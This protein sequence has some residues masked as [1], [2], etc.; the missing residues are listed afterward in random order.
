[1]NKWILLFLTLV[2]LTSQNCKSL[3]PGTNERPQ[4]LT[5]EILSGQDV[6]MSDVNIRESVSFQDVMDD[7]E[8]IVIRGA[9]KFQNCTFED[10]FDLIPPMSG[11]LTFDKEVVFEGCIFKSGFKINDAIFNGRFQMNDCLVEGSLDIQ[12]NTFRHR[13][14]I[15][16]SKVGQDLIL[17]YSRMA[18]DLSIFETEAGRH[19]SL[20]GISVAGLCQLSSSSMG[21]S[22]VISNAHFHETFMANYVNIGKKLL[23]GNSRFNGRADFKDLQCKD[24]IKLSNSEFIGKMSISLKNGSPEVNLEDCFFLQGAPAFH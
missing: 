6:I 10:S 19:F 5:Q 4:N 12:R 17:Q 23:A 7:H 2:G 13:C 21:Y 20:Q 15:D 11:Q 9:I 14:R 16:K 3:A 1:M 22:M 24:H 18:H 8:H